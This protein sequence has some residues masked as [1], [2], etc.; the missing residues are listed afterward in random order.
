[1]KRGLLAR[2]VSCSVLFGGA[3]TFAAWC[4][5]PV[6]TAADETAMIP[7]RAKVPGKLRLNLRGRVETRAGS[8]EYQERSTVVDW[9]VAETAI[10]ICDM[11]DDHYCRC[12]KQRVNAMA[13]RVNQVITAAR[14]HGV[15]IIHAPSGTMKTYQDTEFRK[16]MMQAPQVEPP[17]PIQPWCYLDPKK[18]GALPIDDTD[19]GC[20]DP[21]P[22][23]AVGNY[24]NQHPAI[25]MVGPDGVSDSG[26]EIYNFCRQ[27]G[28]TNIAMMGVH[29]NMCVLGRP[30]G[31]RQLRMLGINVVLV[32][33][34]TDAMYNPRRP[35]YVSHTR[36]T[37]L[38]VE[39]IE[40]HWCPSILS[41]DLARVV[42]G[43]ADAR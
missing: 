41:E 19:K 32:R 12:A 3:M 11:W 22:P 6:A 10:I 18:E 4:S 14:S 35:P 25:D 13:P 27:E 42:P 21:I 8:G 20:D 29:T 26:V 43:S 15:Q 40:K 38:V 36:G 7:N 2:V 31:I 37:E 9:N 5:R 24:K 1:M 30:F 16:R 28:I 33:D 23:P 34:L 39:H 17:V